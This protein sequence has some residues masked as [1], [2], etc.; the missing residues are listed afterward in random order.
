MALPD[1][2]EA[3][4]AETDARI[5]AIQRE[6]EERAAVIRQEGSDAA[7]AAETALA[8]ARAEE[9]ARAQ[10]RIRNRA[11]LE[12]DRLV[13]EA[14]EAIVQQIFSDVELRLS[15]L[16]ET[17]EHA[18]LFRQLAEEAISVLPEASVAHVAPHD[19]PRARA[20]FDTD[21]EVVADLETR[22]G[23]V[24]T[25]R[26]GRTVH[27]TLEVRVQRAEPH[28]RRLIAQLVPELGA[29]PS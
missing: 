25:S 1:I 16:A 11:R 23:L 6:A 21:V 17:E 5:L 8:G 19:E 13:R 7:A 18:G 24:L 15:R 22:G 14:R 27:N 29:R 20:F 3:I 28:M 10:D 4:R 9:A 26:D 12:S 2:V